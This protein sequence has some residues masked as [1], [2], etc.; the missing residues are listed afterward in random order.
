[1]TRAAQLLNVV[2][3]A[4]SRQLHLLE[5]DLGVQ[6]FDR[7]ARG[8]VLTEA[9]T[10]LR[11]YARRVMLELERARA[12]L[13]SSATEVAGIVTL[14]LLPS[15][16]E[17]LP[18]ALLD[19]VTGA[20][21]KVSIRFAL[22]YA[23]TVRQWLDR[24]EVDAAVLYNADHDPLVQAR[25][26]LVEPLWLVGPGLAQLTKMRPVSVGDL[27]GRPMI[28]PGVS[29]HVRT[30]IDAACA[31]EGVQL[32][33][34]AESNAMDVLKELVLGG[35]G[36]TVLPPISFAGERASG[37]L[38]G[39]PIAAAGLQRTVVLALPTSRTPGRHVLAVARI[40]VDLIRMAV[41]TGRWPEAKWIGDEC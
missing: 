16:R 6:L 22:G 36:Y 24:G 2:Q 31:G 37:R 7:S 25:P 38:S 10:T 3:P 41:A 11:A 27:A 14:G 9:G 5:E 26:L 1:M 17:V 32:Q 35:H 23:V 40:L 15:T 39:A 33:V 12:E 4:L 13:Q 29:Q 19:A 21:P 30:L 34:V 8:M 18:S 20:Y 28:L